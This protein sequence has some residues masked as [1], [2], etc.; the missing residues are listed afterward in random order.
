MEKCE[1]FNAP[2]NNGITEEGHCGHSAGHLSLAIIAKYYQI[3]VYI[4]CDSYKIG[5][6]DKKPGIMERKDQWLKGISQ[7]QWH[8]KHNFNFLNLRENIVD[9]S[10]I[11]KIITEEGKFT[12][13]AFKDKYTS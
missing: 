12:I 9:S 1:L 3:P 2:S 8:Q 10:L 13:S 4:L 11:D 5:D 6:M 7:W